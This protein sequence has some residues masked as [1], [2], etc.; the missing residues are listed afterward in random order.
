MEL[1]HPSL[2]PEGGDGG[3]ETGMGETSPPIVDPESSIG[4]APG[5]GSRVAF[6]DQIRGAIKRSGLSRYA[7][8][9]ATGTDQALL[10]RFM[11]GKSGLSLDTLDRIAQALDLRISTGNDTRKKA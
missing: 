5:V 3:P 2:P 4:D 9:K 6:S 11:A 1:S 8:C 10:S 7:I